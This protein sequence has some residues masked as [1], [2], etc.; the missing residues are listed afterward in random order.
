MRSEELRL[1]EESHA[2][3]K[4]DSSVA[5]RGM[6]TC[7]ESRTELKLVRG[8]LTKT[9]IYLLPCQVSFCHQSS[10]VNRKAW[11][12]PLELHE[13]KKYPRK[14]CG[15]SQPRDHLIQVLSERSVNDGGEF[16]LCS[17]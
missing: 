14:T 10:P 4:P 17:W 13:L 11:T 3:V 12:L 7:S 15:C 6:K 8:P 9:N 2:A 5:P 1:V 16:V